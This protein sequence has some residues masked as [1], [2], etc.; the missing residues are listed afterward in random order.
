M[1]KNFKHLLNHRVILFGGIA[2]TLI[3]TIVILS[4]IW[5]VKVPKSQSTDNNFS[6]SID[7]TE[8]NSSNP[9][10]YDIYEDVDTTLHSETLKLISQKSDIIDDIERNITLDTINVFLDGKQIKIDARPFSYETRV[11]LPLRQVGESL[12]V[13]IGWN[14]EHR[15]AI[16]ETPT[17]R[18]ELPVNHR[19]AIR[20]PTN[21]PEHVERLNI[22]LSSRNI[23]TTLFNSTTYLPIRFTA[24]ALGYSVKFDDNNSAVLFTSPK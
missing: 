1:L 9:A 14:I 10:D 20:F 19:K 5:F 23:G 18:L 4:I 6:N 22:D 17:L 12:Q 13:K 24:E 21:N 3:I 15:T 16:V 7:V 11:F 8:N 2:F